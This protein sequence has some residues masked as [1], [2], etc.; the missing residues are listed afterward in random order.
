VTKRT[1]LY[2]R[3]KKSEEKSNT[4]IAIL[5]QCKAKIRELDST[6]VHVSEGRILVCVFIESLTNPTI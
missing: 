3:I 2:R 1:S 5:M 4:I 6:V